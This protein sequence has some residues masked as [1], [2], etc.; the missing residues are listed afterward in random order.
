MELSY[1][2]KRVKILRWNWVKSK[3]DDNVFLIVFYVF[4][5][6]HYSSPRSASGFYLITFSTY[7]RTVF[8]YFFDIVRNQVFTRIKG[9]LKLHFT[10]YSCVAIISIVNTDLSKSAFS[11][12]Y[13]GKPV[14]HLSLFFCLFSD[15]N[16]TSHYLWN[17]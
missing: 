13:F 6:L 7:L 14:L 12:Y 17:Y 2:M 16:S 3:I 5:I 8:L 15:L 9:A 1:K 4:L 11:S 10:H